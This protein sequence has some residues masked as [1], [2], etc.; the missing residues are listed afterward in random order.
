MQNPFLKYDKLVET[1]FPEVQLEHLEGGTATIKKYAGKP[2]LVNF[3]FTSCP[4]CIEELPALNR[5]KRKYQDKVNFVSIT[6]NDKQKVQKL[7]EKL[8]FDFDNYIDARKLIDKFGIDTYPLSFLLDKDGT[9]KSIL[10]PVP[11]N[12]KGESDETLFEP[13]IQKVL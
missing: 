12:Y 8:Q 3:W 5:L 11:V 1:K 2:T 7:F 10:G 9:I 6:F 4:P 13:I